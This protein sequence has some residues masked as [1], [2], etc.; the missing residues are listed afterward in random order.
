MTVEVGFIISIV[1]ISIA[2]AGF[3]INRKKDNKM[4]GYTMGR[5][6]EKLENMNK[7]LDDLCSKYDG[8]NKELD[9]K[10]S[11]SMLEHEKRFHSK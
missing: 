2:V 11:K 8:I 10:I 6:E 5:I 7:K 3:F 9:D 4:D 1:S